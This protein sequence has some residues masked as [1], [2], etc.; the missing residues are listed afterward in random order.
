M[1]DTVY[2]YNARNT[3][4]VFPTIAFKE[5]SEKIVLESTKHN[6]N[7]LERRETA[8]NERASH[9]T[10]ETQKYNIC[11]HNYF[12]LHI[13]I[14]VLGLEKDFKMQNINYSNHYM[15]IISVDKN[16]SYLI[17]HK[18]LIFR[19]IEKTDIQ[20]IF[21]EK[22]RRNGLQLAERVLSIIH[23]QTKKNSK[24]TKLKLLIG[25]YDAK[26]FNFTATSMINRLIKTF[27]C[28]Y[29]TLD[30]GVSNERIINL[31]GEYIRENTLTIMNRS[32]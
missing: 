12:K 23:D 16:L 13:Q 26:K 7:K 31:I 25:L 29:Q 30:I 14:T 15:D 19:L 6:K 1:F 24:S 28:T 18:N 5:A 17:K 2:K 21:F 22:C 27:R 9:F 3:C 10:V 20:I 32:N 8:P 4:D 11:H